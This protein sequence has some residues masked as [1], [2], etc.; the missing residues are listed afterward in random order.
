MVC[1][2][3]PSPDQCVIN[4][5]LPQSL[6]SYSGNPKSILDSFMPSMDTKALQQ[7]ELLHDSISFTPLRST[8]YETMTIYKYNAYQVFY[9]K[10]FATLEMDKSTTV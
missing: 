10:I 9:H 8:I 3:N 4:G 2:H 6:H 7:R 1:S 5:E